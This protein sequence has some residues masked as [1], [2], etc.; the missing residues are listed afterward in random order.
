MFLIRRPNIKANCID[1]IDVFC[2]GL[3][4][5][6]GNFACFEAKGIGFNTLLSQC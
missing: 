6:I 5:Y 4:F 3:Y 2:V 1:I